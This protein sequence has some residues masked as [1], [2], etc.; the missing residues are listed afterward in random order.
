[1][2]SKKLCI[3]PT[4]IIANISKS[5]PE[6]QKYFLDFQ[7]KYGL[8]TY[9]QLNSRVISAEWN[10]HEGKY[11]VQVENFEGIKQDWCHVLING[12]GVLNNWKCASFI[13]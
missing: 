5:A 11:H 1:M 8:E 4:S 9:V 6:I 12:S 10:E 13:S 7:S 3:V 2:R